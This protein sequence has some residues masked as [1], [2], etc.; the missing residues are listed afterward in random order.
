M[1]YQIII[2]F[3]LLAFLNASALSA[4][5]PRTSLEATSCDD[6]YLTIFRQNYARLFAAWDDARKVESENHLR[7]CQSVRPRFTTFS[8]PDDPNEFVGGFGD[9]LLGMV[10]V[11]YASLAT[12]TTF[13][14]KWNRPYNI[15]SYFN[16]PCASDVPAG[17]KKII[18]IDAWDH[19]LGQDWR[20]DD[21]NNLTYHTNARHWKH[22]VDTAANSNS[23]PSSIVTDLRV[24]QLSE[25]MLF[26]VAIDT[27]FA[28]PMS[29]IRHKTDR[30]LSYGLPIVGVQI[31][32]GGKQPA[33]TDVATRHPVQ[34]AT[35]F[36]EEAQKACSALEKCLI[37][38]TSD[39]V[40]AANIF[41]ERLVHVCPKHLC[42]F[43]KQVHGQALHTDRTDNNDVAGLTQHELDSL[44]TKS[45]LDWWLLKHA[46]A[47]IISRSGFGE[48]AAMASNA[49]MIRQLALTENPDK[50]NFTNI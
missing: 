25:R 12:G 10:T 29:K 47:L 19:F 4:S 42:R 31:R 22:V 8:I 36:A 21:H 20:N 23:P 15:K 41:M 5:E 46:D 35:C 50:C 40:P 48:T 32:T 33:F 14:I 1:L 9:R 24:D 43:V 2:G 3:T 39:S 27:L 34:S 28:H 44:W 49:V 38:L 18:S 7:P 30:I 6:S 16:V 37:F 26:K 17:A 11:F 13:G 45:V